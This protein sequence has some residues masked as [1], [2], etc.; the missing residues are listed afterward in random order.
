MIP[1]KGQ[2]VKCLLRSN[3]LAEGTV[4]EWDNN[5]VKLLSLDE[6]SLLI[7]HHPQDDIILTKVILCDAPLDTKDKIVEVQPELEEQF[8]EVYE[9]PS[10]DDLRTKRMVELKSLLAA[11]EKK[12]I[13][14]QLKD[15][16]IAEVKEVKYGYP[17]FFSK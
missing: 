3:T 8:Q 14:E 6:K 10:G 7:I 16:K 1:E 4:E 2:H 12:I 11:Q 9:Q 17:G 13:A 5:I 15:H